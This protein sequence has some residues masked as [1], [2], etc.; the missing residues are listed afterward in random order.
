MTVRHRIVANTYKDSVALMAISSKIL[1]IDGVESASVVMATPTNLEN[2]VEASLS[3]GLGETKPSDLVVAVSGTDD[4]CDAALALADDLLA[5]QPL[6]AGGAVAE[7]PV[8]STQMAVA[9]DPALNFALVSVPGAY[10]AAEAIKA[11]RLGMSVMVFSDNVPVEQELAM[12]TLAAER[13]VMVMGPDC[14][15]AIVNGLPLGFANVV[16]RGPIGVVGASGTGVQEVTARIHNLGS[17][18]SQALGTGGHDLSDDIG[19][20]S[21]LH[22][23]RSLEQ[24]PG[25]SVIVLVSK[26]PSERVAKVVLDE[27]RAMST[28]VV[29]IFLGADPSTFSDDKIHGVGTLADAAD[30]AVSLANGDPTDAGAVVSGTLSGA[31]SMETRRTLDDAARRMSSDQRYVRGIFCGGTFCFEAQLLCQAAGIISGS[32]TPVTGNRML[33]DIRV[34]VEHTIVD[35]GDDEFTQGRP[36][37]MIDPTLRNERVALD[38]ADPTTAVLLIDVVLGYGSADDPLSGLLE[39]LGNA[40]SHAKGAGRH[41]AVVAHVCGTDADPQQRGDIVAKLRSTGA[42][43]ASS[44]AEAARWAAHIATTAGSREHR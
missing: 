29:V 31:L 6:D 42:L 15:T 24:D 12:K 43:L 4:A 26:P 41:L 44:N 16:R 1:A 36:H 39:V 11:I 25:T 17:G 18:V 2:L 5:E 28:P 33:D 35:M 22:G 21:M 3:D 20:I 38:A 7:L 13:G 30:L 23:L 32:N 8:S 14:G 19:G 10:A 9:A 34:S 40:R 27:A 37:P